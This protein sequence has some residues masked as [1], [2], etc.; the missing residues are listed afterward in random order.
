[1]DFQAL[2]K[3]IEDAKFPQETADAI[4]NIIGMAASKGNLTDQEEEEII[5]L[6]D[7]AIVSNKKETQKL[8][9]IADALQDLQDVLSENI[10][11]AYKLQQEED[12]VSAPAA[13]TV[14]TP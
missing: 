9:D 11:E 5:N 2:K 6:I 7:D 8:L 13:P 1:M 10:E 12:Q 14:Q 3:I 4:N